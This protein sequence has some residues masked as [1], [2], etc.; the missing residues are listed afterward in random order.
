MFQPEQCCTHRART[1]SRFPKTKPG[2]KE[3]PY[4]FANLPMVDSQATASVP[5]PSDT[6]VLCK[7][8]LIELVIQVLSHFTFDSGGIRA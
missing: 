4:L 8:D 2:N 3:H 5:P 6:E 7:T 1:L